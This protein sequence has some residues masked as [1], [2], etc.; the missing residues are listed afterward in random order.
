MINVAL[1]HDVDRIRKTYQYITHTLKGFSKM[2]FSNSVKSMFLK[3]NCYWNIDEIMEIEKSYNV[4]S[5]FFFLNESIRFELFKKKSWKLSMGRYSIFETKVRDYIR[6]LDQNGWEIGVHGSY[7]SYKSLEL[8]KKEKEDLESII[9]HKL[10]GIRQHYLNMAENTWELQKAAG[11][12][13]DSSFGYLDKI[14]FKESRI[15]PFRPFDDYFAVFPLSVMD[16]CFMSTAGRWNAFDEILDI[17]DQYNALIVVNWHS[18]I[19]NEIEYPDY[20]NNYIKI[21]E[22]CLN[23]GAKFKTLSEFYTNAK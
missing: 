16:Y 4:K 8:L 3:R 6:L 10:I 13:Y 19:F 14:G 1:T 5:T 11:F 20:K 21:I 23:R 7:N 22:K 2:R 15:L 9:N 12:K 18:N 17:A